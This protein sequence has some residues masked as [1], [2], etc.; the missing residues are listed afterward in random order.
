[1]NVFKILSMLPLIENYNDINEWIE[2][3]TKS[4]ELWDIKEQE[5]RNKCVNKEIKYI[6]DELRE[7]KNQVPSLKEIKIALEEYLEITPKVKYWNLINLKI[8]SN[9]SISNFNYKYERKYDIDSN[10]K[11]L[12]TANNYVNSIKSR[13]YPCLRILEEIKDLNEALKYAEKV[14][15]IE[16]KLN[17]NLNNIYKYN[18]QKWNYNNCKMKI[19]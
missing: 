1:M 3:L 15:R 17:L 2:E 13:I 4:F 19:K 5:R 18:K 12:I 16:K 11:K 14:E 7:K 8:N 6:L 9:E 10:I